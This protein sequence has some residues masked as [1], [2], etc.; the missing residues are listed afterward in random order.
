MA[1]IEQIIILIILL[2]LS[3]FFSGSE[4]A[5]LSLTKLKARQ[6]F[7]KK[8]FGAVYIKKLKDD[9]QRM[10]ATILIGNN[11][12]NVAASAIATSIMINIFESYAIGIATGVMTFL[13]L[14][15][16]EITPKSIAA[17]NN[18]LVSQIVAAPIWY[19]SII[20][21]PIL[22]ILDKFLNR[23]INLIGIKAQ[24]RTITEEEIKSMIKSAEEEGSI[25]EIE[26]KM[27][28]S[29]F[30]FDDINVGEIATPRTDMVTMNSKL[31]IKK[32]MKI[33]L[34]KKYSRIPVYEKYKDNI[35]GIVY[36]RDV[37]KHMQDRNKNLSISKIMNK[38]YFVPEAKKI[39]SLL[40]QFQKRKEH[41]AIVVDEHGSITGLVT[42]EDVLEEIVGEIMD[43]TDK[44]AP[45]IEKIGKDT[46]IVNGKVDI[47]EVNE[48]LNMKLKGKG[49]DTLSG[50]ILKHTG[51]IPK[52][53]DEIVY[54]EFRFKIEEIEGHRISKVSVKKK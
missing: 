3:G 40:R 18:E 15:F 31:S 53:D 32:A 30:E 51:K 41:M 21:A 19:L 37:I 9:P 36:V 17:K 7:D 50:F 20:L 24:E 8:R 54:N 43:E 25:K 48:K 11:L 13:I 33:I 42:M 38:P 5:L 46:W 28:N 14:V 6:M 23:F 12:V 10:L 29:I 34:K 26:K 2:I 52:E 16:G 1:L 4:V 44:I 22:N 39:S 49:Y 27:I 45:N 35:V 47:D